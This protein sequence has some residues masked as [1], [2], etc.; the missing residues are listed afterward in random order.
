[1][2]TINILE[3]INDRFKNGYGNISPRNVFYGGQSTN[4]KMNYVL[5]KYNEK[6]EIYYMKCNVGQDGKK[7]EKK[8]LD[9]IRKI[10]DK[11]NEA[12]FM[13]YNYRGNKKDYRRDIP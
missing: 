11:S 9:D 12:V 1:M 2:V 5:K 6:I 7:I 3:Y 8:I 10:N 13:L 4:C